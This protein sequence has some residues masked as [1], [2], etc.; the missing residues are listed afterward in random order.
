MTHMAIFFVYLQR[1]VACRQSFSFEDMGDKKLTWVRRL[2]ISAIARLMPHAVATGGEMIGVSIC[3]FLIGLSGRL[4]QY[5]RGPGADN[6][7]REWE[8]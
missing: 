3:R 7:G 8:L 1:F 2:V 4:N 5:V 6:N